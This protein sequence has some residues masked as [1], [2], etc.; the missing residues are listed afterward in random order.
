[1]SA[2][3]CS[4]AAVPQHK[5]TLRIEL[6]DATLSR[7]LVSGRMEHTAIGSGL[8]TATATPDSITAEAS[9]TSGQIGTLAGNLKVS[10]DASRWQDMPIDG[11][12]R[13]Q[14]AKLDLLS[15]YVPDIDRVQGNLTADARIAGT[16][17]QPRLSGTLSV[18]DGEVDLYQTNLR[19][20]QIGLTAHLTDDGVV[21]GGSA[22]AG[23]GTV[24]A[25]GE[26]HWRDTLPY[27]QLHLDGANLRVVDIPEAQI[28][29]SPSLDFKVAAHEIDIT[30]KVAVPYAKIVPADLTG[31]VSSSSDEVI[32][33][34]ESQNPAD[35]F[36][37]KTQITMTLGPNVNIDTLGLT[38]Q[39]AGSITVRSGYD[40]ITRATGELSVQKGEYSAYA[41]KLDIQSGRLIFTGGPIEDPG[42]EIRAVKRYPDVTAGINVRGTLQEPRLSFFSSPSLPQSQIVSLILSGG[43]GGSTLQMMQATSA[44]Q[45]QQATATSELLTQG[46]AILAQQLGSRIGLPDIS[47]ETDLNNETSLVLGKY[48][49]PRLYVSYGV[50]L[51]EE[52]NAIRLRYSLGDHWTIRTTAGQIKG[53]DLVFSVEK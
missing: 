20:R 34:K 19:L 53:A 23:K 45:N 24:R 15:L 50:G 46:G 33:G 12:L 37:V 31:A 40:A 38:G 3:G 14:T 22:Q 2:R 41:R 4:A 26:V 51:T 28:D 7:R 9:L 25:D 32:V 13:A 27:G 44:A 8:L 21:F 52:L 17:A 11:E 30:G 10:R 42:I 36:Q 49:S 48:L 6:S 5:G 35:Q 43:G 18:S 1:M 16:V 47:V 39:L 29:A